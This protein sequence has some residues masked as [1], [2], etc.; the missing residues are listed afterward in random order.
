MSED[1]DKEIVL[2][3]GASLNPPDIKFVPQGL[4][5]NLPSY[6]E[7]RIKSGSWG[8]GYQSVEETHMSYEALR[9]TKSR[10]NDS[11]KI[12]FMDAATFACTSAKTM[13]TKVPSSIQD[14]V[15]R[16]PNSSCC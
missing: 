15:P 16:R 9:S 11:K 1:N 12:L 5:C 2:A 3:L 6:N 8:F 13:T 4:L 14:I 10:P 7:E